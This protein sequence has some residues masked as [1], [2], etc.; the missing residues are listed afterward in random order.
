MVVRQKFYE[1]RFYQEIQKPLFIEKETSR[2]MN[3]ES[4]ENMDTDKGEF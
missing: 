2:S 1:K 4:F 3:L